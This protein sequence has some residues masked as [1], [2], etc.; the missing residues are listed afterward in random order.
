MVHIVYTCLRVYNLDKEMF[1]ILCLFCCKSSVISFMYFVHY[2]YLNMFYTRWFCNF[3]NFSVQYFESWG[4]KTGKCTVSFIV[5]YALEIEKLD[6]L[7]Q[8]LY[9]K[10]IEMTYKCLYCVHW[11][12]VDLFFLCTNIF[13]EVPTFRHR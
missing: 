3:Y 1:Q 11:Y 8:F 10:L 9:F 13:N 4:F 6:V 7:H 12:H 2:N 5:R